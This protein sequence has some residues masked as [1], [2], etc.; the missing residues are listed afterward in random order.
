MSEQEL[1]VTNPLQAASEV[2]YKPKAVFTAVGKVNGWSWVPFI[3]VIVM[4]ILPVYLY[5]HVVDLSWL[6]NQMALAA[7]PDGSPA[8]I[9]NYKRQMP[10]N[11]Y[12]YSYFVIPI[13]ISL[14]T[15]IFAGYFTFVT[16]NDETNVQGFTD[17]YGAMWWIYM[18][19]IINSFF[20]CL[21]LA[22][23]EQNVQVNTAIMAPLSMAYIFGLDM[24]SEAFNFLSNIRLDSLWSILLSAYCVNTWTSF[25]FKKSMI[26]ALI[27]YAVI[28]G[29]PFL[30]FI[31]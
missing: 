8:E 6:V 26:I 23:Q 24:T 18:P 16:R 13:F 21:L 27:P 31:L 25:N 30:F 4:G 1:S 17:W 29:I 28:W 20:A 10:E 12:V 15:A 2:F 3:L 9:E 19:T 22:L 14:I 7:N 5:Y 11:F